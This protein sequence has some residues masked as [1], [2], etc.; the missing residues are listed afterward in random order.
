MAYAEHLLVV[1]AGTLGPNE[2]WSTGCRFIP[3]AAV[4]QPVPTSANLDDTVDLVQAGV[5][6]QFANAG[7]AIAAGARLQF[8]KMNW[9]LPNGKYRDPVTHLHEYNPT[10]NGPAGPQTPDFTTTA[11]SLETGFKR[12]PAHA[13]RQYWPN[14]GLPLSSVVPSLVDA[15][16]RSNALN[17]YRSMLAIAVGGSGG[18]DSW[19]YL[20]V[21][22]SRT[23]GVNKRVTGFRMGNVL[24]VQRRRK[25]S[26]P[27]T[28]VTLDLT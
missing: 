8:F 6:T 28:F 14:F 20:P 18:V 17:W 4:G 24:D 10:I 1:W 16:A 19:S 2:I 3:N 13:G 12:G 25:E 22:A 23:Y 5:A 7:G 26:E 15:S 11:I 21:V 9:I 27:E